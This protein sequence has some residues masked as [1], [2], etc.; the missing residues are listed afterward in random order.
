MVRRRPCLSVSTMSGWKRRA[1]KTVIPSPRI[2]R[3]S[4]ARKERRSRGSMLSGWALSAR[5]RA[6]VSSRTSCRR[7]SISARVRSSGWVTVRLDERRAMTT[8]SPGPGFLAPESR[9]FTGPSRPPVALADEN[10][11]FLR[12]ADKGAPGGFGCDISRQRAAADN[13]SDLIGSAAVLVG[14]AVSEVFGRVAHA[15]DGER[16]FDPVRLDD[17]LLEEDGREGRHPFP[18]ED[19]GHH[20]GLQELP[21]G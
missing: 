18:D 15:R 12:G 16:G 19:A 20:R 1:A 14:P 17:D 6:S 3:G 2:A 8:T 4:R 11:G 7:V 21:A 13:A 5:S 10:A 9:P